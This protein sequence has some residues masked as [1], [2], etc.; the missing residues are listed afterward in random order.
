MPPQRRSDRRTGV[1]RDHHVKLSLSADEYALL[2]RAAD[3]HGMTV[4][5]YAA[6]AC[7][8][9]ARTTLDITPG[10]REAL[11]TLN[12]GIIA[13]AALAD[14]LHTENLGPAQLHRAT[15]AID[16]LESASD[17]VQKSARA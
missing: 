4:G 3:Q 12:E 17:A 13:L 11:V 2:A 7:L 9:A 8:G 6:Y 15:D 14:R 5:G 10:L 1:R 16:T